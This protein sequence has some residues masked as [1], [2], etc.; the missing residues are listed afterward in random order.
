MCENNEENIPP[1]VFEA[2]RKATLNLLPQKSRQQYELVFKKF[3]EWSIRIILQNVRTRVHVVRVCSVVFAF[4][5]VFPGIF[6]SEFSIA[7]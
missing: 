5:R 3:N 6:G 1:E 4:C 2:A 7:A